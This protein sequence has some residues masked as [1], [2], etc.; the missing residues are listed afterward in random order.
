MSDKLSQAIQ[1]QVKEVYV[2]DKEI[3]AKMQ[4]MEKLLPEVEAIFNKLNLEILDNPSGMFYTGFTWKLRYKK[5]AKKTLIF[6]VLFSDSR[7]SIYVYH[8]KDIK[9]YPKELGHYHEADLPKY[10]ARSFPDWLRVEEL[11][12]FFN[13]LLHLIF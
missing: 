3:H 6:D 9:D 8:A 12:E 10:H 11:E 4:D 2:T 7:F 1:N 13:D 5:P